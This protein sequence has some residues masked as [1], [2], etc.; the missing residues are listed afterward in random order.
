MVNSC[1]ILTALLVVGTAVL[2]VP[3]VP[4]GIASTG[5]SG[6]VGI[7]PGSGGME[8]GSSEPGLPIR[9]RQHDDISR[10]PPAAEGRPGAQPSRSFQR[11]DPEGIAHQEMLDYVKKYPVLPPKYK[12]I[13]EQVDHMMHTGKSDSHPDKTTAAF[14]NILKVGSMYE[15]IKMYIEQNGPS[16]TSPKKLERIRGGFERGE[17]LDV[18]ARIANTP[19]SE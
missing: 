15:L 1:S 7:Q 18:L 19:N 6:G 3:I 14:Q 16:G 5:M 9:T 2:A 13:V 17:D 11:R 10:G 8:A 4:E 12:Q